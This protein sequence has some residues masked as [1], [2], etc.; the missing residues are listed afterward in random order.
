MKNDL[1]KAD[2]HIFW[3]FRKMKKDKIT[4]NNCFFN[5]IKKSV[6]IHILN[7]IFHASRHLLR[8]SLVRFIDSLFGPGDGFRLTLETI[9]DRHF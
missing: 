6:L 5:I 2:N 8:Y 1:Y 7:G 9:A 3:E 4:E